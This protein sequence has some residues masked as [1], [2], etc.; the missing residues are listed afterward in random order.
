MADRSQNPFSFL[1]TKVVFGGMLAIILALGGVI[2]TPMLTLSVPTIKLMIDD[3]IKCSSVATAQ[4]IKDLDTSKLSVGT[5]VAD[6][7]RRAE[8]RNGMEERTDIKL[9]AIDDKVTSLNKKVDR[10]D[11]GM[12]KLLDVYIKG[13]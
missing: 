13:K 1:S 11:R 7:K 9:K 3:A 8:E 2:V 5:Y 4:Q 12:E 6:E 10:I